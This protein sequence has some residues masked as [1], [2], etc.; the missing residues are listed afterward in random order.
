V[1]VARRLGDPDTVAYALVA[2]Y[3][4]I[5]GPD[6][7]DDLLEIATEVVELATQ[8]GNRD[9]LLEGVL[10]RHKAL[11]SL[12]DLDAAR[13]EHA[14]A[15]R[16][17]EELRQPAQ[18]WYVAADRATLAL[19]EAR[20]D[21]AEV[22]VDRALE[23]GKRSQPMEARS[24]EAIQR[25][26]LRR[27]QGRL[28]EAEPILRRASE[29]FPWYPHFRCGFANMYVELGEVERARALVADLARDRFSRIPVDNE[30]LFAMCLVAEPVAAVA[31]TGTVA[32]LFDLLS[33]FAGLSAYSAPELYL[34]TVTLYL[35]L[36]AAR[37][38]RQQEAER[39]L[40]D[41]VLRSER[42]GATTW[43][44]RSRYHLADVLRRRGDQSGRQRAAEVAGTTREMAGRVG[45]TAMEER[46]AALV[47]DLGE[48]AATEAGPPGPSVLRREGEY[49]SIAFEGRAFRL[50]D[51]KG[52]HHLAT[53]LAAP[54]REVH[55]L[56]LVTAGQGTRGAGDTH[57]A[58]EGLTVGQLD[59][60]DDVLDPQARESY[61]RRL[62]ELE[63]EIEEA[64]AW[65]DPERA[66]RAEEERDAIIGELGAAMGLG[67][68]SRKTAT[69]AER[70]RVNATR[71]IRAALARIAEHDRSLGEH[72]SAT[73]ATGT[74]CS[75][76]PD[77]RAEMVWEITP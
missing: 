8:V 6:N 9:R 10:I 3:T 45:L 20:L 55:A 51:T 64:R 41:A 46:L 32:I 29:D 58:A 17:A 13:S 76:R 54:G 30:W 21:E 1:E 74:Y 7:T 50:K 27:E 63:E 66:A 65:A 38:G 77:P 72:L 57:P 49:W 12:G 14:A 11:M 60:G 39:Y 70:A 59:T 44:V 36:L 40:E 62:T 71:A 56:D 22:L 67:G 19:L 34:G 28:E 47:D 68:R 31:D 15:T 4:A 69:A 18:A 37:L 35:G 23:V 33:P 5:W 48:G 75:Y 25:W 53:L 42:T 2:R 43:V 24:T 73:V 61:K 26:A 16:L 52:L